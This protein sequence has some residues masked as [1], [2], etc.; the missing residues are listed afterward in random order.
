MEIRER[1]QRLQPTQASTP[2][3]HEERHVCGRVVVW[4][5]KGRKHKDK[6]LGIE[7]FLFSKNTALRARS[8]FLWTRSIF[9]AK[10]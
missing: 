1:Q 10:K 3:S 5:S 9:P 8:S 6:H 4:P 2:A 7:N